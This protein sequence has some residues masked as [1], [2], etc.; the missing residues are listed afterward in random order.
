MLKYLDVIATWI[1]FSTLFIAA[2]VY[3]NVQYS[4]VPEAL[5]NVE[6]R[7]FGSV[8][9]GNEY[10]ATGTA[11]FGGVVVDKT[12]KR[13]W[14]AVGSIIVTKAGDA[15]YKLFDATGTDVL[16]TGFGTVGQSSSTQL[17]AEIPADLAAGTYTVDA[18]FNYG[19]VLD[20]VSGDT[21]TTT[22]TY[23]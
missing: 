21:G 14:G 17:I 13:G 18:N 11:D 22:V 15:E 16:T 2:L 23:R 7:S 19:L 3:L 6:E 1:I 12:I 8:T 10:N 5:P 9:V 4:V 20:V